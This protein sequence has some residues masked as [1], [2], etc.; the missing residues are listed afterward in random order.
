MQGRGRK[1]AK[2]KKIFDVHDLIMTHQANAFYERIIWPI[3]SEY[4]ITYNQLLILLIADDC[5]GIQINELAFCFGGAQS[6]VSSLCKNLELH[7]LMERRREGADERRV[8]VE[9]TP[10][11]QEIINALKGNL[12]QSLTQKTLQENLDEMMAWFVGK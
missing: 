3:I 9:V 11:G 12:G 2:V 1:A 10:A 8:M 4:K 6:N 5:P 7:G